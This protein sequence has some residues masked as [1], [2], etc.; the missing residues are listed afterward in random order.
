V[1][2]VREMWTSTPTAPRYERWDHTLERANEAATVFVLQAQLTTEPTTLDSNALRSVL[3]EE[4]RWELT[5][6]RLS[7]TI[8]DDVD[9]AERRGA[10]VV[11]GEQGARRWLQGRVRKGILRF[12]ARREFLVWKAPPALTD[13]PVIYPLP[14]VEGTASFF[15]LLAAYGEE[16]GLEGTLRC[17]LGFWRP[18]GLRLGPQRPGTTAWDWG[19]ARWSPAHDNTNIERT[20]DYE[21]SMVRH[22]PDRVAHSFVAHVYEDFGYDDDD[23]PFWF[24]EE[25]RFVFDS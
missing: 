1:A 25:G 11:V 7:W 8:V 3:S 21:W 16:L 20:A 17:S 4:R 2:E 12:E 18:E 9:Q 22:T 6:R 13:E 23:I 10:D 19:G 15:W 24:P 14:L 5:R